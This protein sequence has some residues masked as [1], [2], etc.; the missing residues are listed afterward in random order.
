M[1]NGTTS[2]AVHQQEAL[3]LNPKAHLYS[4]RN[5]S[6][7]ALNYRLPIP[8]YSGRHT[9]RDVGCALR[10]TCSWD[11]W[12]TGASTWSRAASACSTSRTFIAWRWALI[13]STWDIVQSSLHNAL[14]AAETKV[15]DPT[16]IIDA[17]N[18]WK[19]RTG[20]HAGGTGRG[21][22]SS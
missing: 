15:L 8:Y 5:K 20:P 2:L 3:L 7:D 13:T 1:E 18:V 22:W 4:R 21:E 19:H 11:V 9:I 17:H 12:F 16:C 10:F 6:A 14:P